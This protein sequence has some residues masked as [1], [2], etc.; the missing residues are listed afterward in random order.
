[1]QSKFSKAYL[2]VAANVA[3]KKHILNFI[4]NNIH[5]K[6]VRQNGSMCLLLN[7]F[8]D[9]SHAL[10]LV[11]VNSWCSVSLPLKKL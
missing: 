9:V 10:K 2:C 5:P 7:Q 3:L 8:C 1:M 6:I 11:V 4:N